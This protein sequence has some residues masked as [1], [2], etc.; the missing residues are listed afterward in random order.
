MN[1]TGLLVILDTRIGE[2]L[3]VLQTARQEGDRNP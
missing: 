2:R 3:K 1:R